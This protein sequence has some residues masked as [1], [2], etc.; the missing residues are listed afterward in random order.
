MKILHLSTFDSGGA[1]IA[2]LRLHEA[3]L[4]AGMD[5]QLLVMNSRSYGR[6]KVKRFNPIVKGFWTKARYK[7]N[8][9]TSE[10]TIPFWLKKYHW[11]YITPRSKVTEL[12]SMPWTMQPL[13]ENDDF[14]QADVIHLHWIVGFADVSLIK[15]F[16]DKKFVWTL[17]DMN[18]FTAGCHYSLGC[19][20]Y[21]TNCHPCP[22]LNEETYS[23]AFYAYKKEWLQTCTNLSIVTPSAW[24]GKLSKQS[25]LFKGYPHHHIQNCIN[26]KEFQILDKTFARKILQLSPDAIIFL[27]VAA[28]T[29]NPRKGITYIYE[30]AALYANSNIHFVVLGNPPDK[31]IPNMSSLG[32]LSDSY[33]LNLCYASADAFITP[34]IEDNLPNVI[35]ESLY[36]GTPV[37]GFRIGGVAEMISDGSNGYLSD[38][39]STD[40]LHQVCER[41]IQQNEKFNRE[42]IRKNALSLY[43][44][45]VVVNKYV[46]VYNI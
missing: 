17:H 11:Q 30:L 12:Y 20:N 43:S 36:C 42:L 8:R 2:A 31:D 22:M 13:Q 21:K 5:S 1:G 24:L 25:H 7:L 23:D 46:Q 14:L 28:D 33:A 19:N 29:S 4:S 45:D 3:M 6:K 27:F 9:I 32:Y 38:E 44:P 35:V 37:L 18:P 34:S 15:K 40:G 41:F 10:L 26:P 39:V 16:P